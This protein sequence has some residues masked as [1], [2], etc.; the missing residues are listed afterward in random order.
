MKVKLKQKAN[1]TLD[2]IMIF[3]DIVDKGHQLSITWFKEEYF[4]VLLC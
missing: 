4:P 1:N 3:N 2:Y